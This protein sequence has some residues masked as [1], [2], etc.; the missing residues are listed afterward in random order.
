METFYR[1]S[2]QHAANLLREHTEYVEN[3]LTSHG[4]KTATEII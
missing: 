1:L 4:D 3:Q 2:L